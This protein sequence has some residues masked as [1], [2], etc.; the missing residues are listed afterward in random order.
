MSRST[1]PAIRFWAAAHN[2]ELC[3]TPTNAS[4]ADPIE[5]QFGPL[6]MFTLATPTAGAFAALGGQDVGVAVV[7]VA[8]AQV[9]VQIRPGWC[10]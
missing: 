10:G 1:T 8:P 2:V 9:G 4:L 7:G 3:L 5:A 6:R